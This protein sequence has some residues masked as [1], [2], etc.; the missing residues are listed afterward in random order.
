M[1]KNVDLIEFAEKYLDV[2]LS[3]WQRELLRAFDSGRTVTFHTKRVH[4][5]IDS[6]SFTKIK[7]EG[8]TK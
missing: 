1:K 6:Q 4:G 3:D 2:K 5:G 8:E 7:N